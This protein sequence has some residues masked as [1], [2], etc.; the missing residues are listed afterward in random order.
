MTR[1]I[2]S[3]Y[4]RPEVL[5]QVA[6]L[7]VAPRGLVEG[8]RAGDHRSPA[9]G[10]AV[11][12][13]S[14][15]PY[16][17]GDDTRHIDWQVYHRHRKLLIRQ[18]EMETNL[19]CHLV[20]DV[21]ASMRYGEGD[22]QKMEYGGRLASILAYLVI[23]RGDR[24][25]LA[26]VDQQVRR[27]VAA[28]VSAAQL[29]RMAG[30]LEE[31]DPVGRTDLAGPLGELAGGFGRRGI[32]V[33]IS[34]F[35]TDLDRLEPAVQ[36]LRYDRHEVVLMQVMHHDELAF[37]FSSMVR[38]VGLEQ[39]RQ[40]TGRPRELRRGYLEALERHQQRLEAICQANR[41]ERVLCDTSR[42]LGQ[43]VADYLQDRMAV[44][45]HRGG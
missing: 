11:E 14:H 18:Y 20:L 21:S 15:R 10:F 22:R 33:L 16:V 42:P 1:P 3:R 38:F 40:V 37:D 9:H 8:R 19:D 45:H 36:R 39:Q 13:A 25:S 27:R 44:T 24:A 6:H 30:A 28:S 12:F 23:E 26:L 34:D 32:V 7:A 17:P 2:L 29:M 31:I 41:C 35:L 4:I 5:A 43:T